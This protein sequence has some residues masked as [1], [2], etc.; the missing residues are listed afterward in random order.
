M[1]PQLLLKSSRFG[2]SN[3]PW[4]CWDGKHVHAFLQ[5]LGAPRGPEQ[6]PYAGGIGHLTS[7][8]T[9]RW[10]EQVPALTPGAP[11]SL[12]D[13]SLYSGSTLFHDGVFHLFYTGRQLAED[14]RIERILQATSQDGMHFARTEP[15]LMVAPDARYYEALPTDSPD[16]TVNWRD[17]DVIHCPDTDEFY[18]VFCART[19]DH[20]GALGLARSKDLLHWEVMPPLFVNPRSQ[21]MEC[22]HWLRVDGR[23]YVCYSQATGWLTAQGRRETP[24]EALEDGVYYVSAPAISGPWTDHD[25]RALIGIPHWQNKP[26]AGAPVTIG[27]ETLFSFNV[28]GCS[29]Y[30]PFKSVLNTANGLRLTWNPRLEPAGGQP[31]P[32]CP[33]VTEPAG[34]GYRF[35]LSP[36]CGRNG[37]VSGRLRRGN[38]SRAGILFRADEYGWKG[39]F[40]ALHF[41]TATLEFGIQSDPTAV[42]TRSLPELTG[43][44]EVAFR[45]L[46][47]DDLVELFLD[48]VLVLSTCTAAFGGDLGHERL[49]V[50]DS[51]GTAAWSE[52]AFTPLALSDARR[53]W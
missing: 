3:D 25:R 22:P 14:C 24:P 45:L 44:E 51:S 29:G 36:A 4:F 52:L 38:A 15:S 5:G 6:E 27:D 23:Y 11:G 43:R 46:L 26:Y 40:V 47:L 16:G 8:D 20:Q 37:I 1:Q 39:L 17:P 19:A 48:D 31:V 18:M 28:H 41:P 13:A 42:R 10:I 9:L 21:M 33:A 50:M 30:V 7:P 32:I 12:D 2:Q 49:G 53:F 34:P 35:S